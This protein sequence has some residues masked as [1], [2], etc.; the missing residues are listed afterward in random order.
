MNTKVDA[1]GMN[2]HPIFVGRLK[3]VVDDFFPQLP[4]LKSREAKVELDLPAELLLKRGTKVK[5]SSSGDEMFVLNQKSGRTYLLSSEKKVVDFTDDELQGMFK[6][7]DVVKVSE[8]IVSKDFYEDS[9]Y[10]GISRSQSRS[11]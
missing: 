9:S 5:F 10:S 6:N 7:G 11:R 3:V 1:V 2:I 4:P 8:P